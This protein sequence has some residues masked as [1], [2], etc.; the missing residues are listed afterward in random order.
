MQRT[1]VNDILN[2]CRERDLTI[3]AFEQLCGLGNGVVGKWEG[4]KYKPSLTSLQKIEAATG[5]PL[6]EWLKQKE[7]I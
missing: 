2:Y 5:I 6:A 3:M 4:D 1:I 7:N